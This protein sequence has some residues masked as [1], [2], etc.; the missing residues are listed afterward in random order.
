M[1]HKDVNG[2]ELNPDKLFYRVYIDG[3]PYTFKASKY[4][5]LLEDMDLVSYN[6]YDAYNFS[7]IYQNKY[8]LFYLE[9]EDWGK[10]EIES[11]YIVD[12]TENVSPA[13]VSIFNPTG[14]NTV[15]TGESVVK[16]VYTNLLGQEVICPQNG[17]VYLKTVLY[18]S[19]KKETHKVVAQ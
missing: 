19:G 2:N 11:V 18:K 10:L 6:Y 13:K 14:I 17:S 9:E 8:K 5:G 12:G 15:D 3:N 7:E 1:P 16:V 4:V